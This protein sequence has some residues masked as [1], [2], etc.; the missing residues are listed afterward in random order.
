MLFNTVKKNYNYLTLCLLHCA[1][2]FSDDTLRNYFLLFIP[3][4]ILLD[5]I[6]TLT[7]TTSLFNYIWVFY[8]PIYVCKHT[9]LCNV[10]F[11]GTL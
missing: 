1:K 10:I 5:F 7:D 3:L 4:D 11:D 2:T 9:S 6:F 8:E